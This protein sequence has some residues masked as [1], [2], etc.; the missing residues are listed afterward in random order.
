MVQMRACYFLVGRKSPRGSEK[1]ETGP[2]Q[3]ADITQQLTDYLFDD[4]DAVVELL[5]LQHW[6]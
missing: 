5:A 2:S 4:V 1:S 3:V 6:M